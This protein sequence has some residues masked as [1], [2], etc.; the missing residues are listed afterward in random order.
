MEEQFS[1][2]ICREII[3]ME[4]RMLLSNFPI[5]EQIIR[6]N[7]KKFGLDRERVVKESVRNWFNAL[8][9]QA[10][11]LVDAV[12][13]E[14]FV[15][16]IK[17]KLYRADDWYEIKLEKEV[18]SDEDILPFTEAIYAEMGTLNYSVLETTKF[19][20]L[21]AEYLNRM[22]K[23]VHAYYIIEAKSCILSFLPCEK[24]LLDRL[25]LN[26]REM[27]KTMVLGNKIY[28]IKGR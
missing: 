25:P 2:Y 14:G 26:L 23:P 24:T 1:L 4:F 20:T 16:K 3:D 15:M 10:T 12:N 13:V 18:V 19:S 27:E 11:K 28:I 6:H 21:C 9:E 17:P 7:I 22:K 8:I 5:T